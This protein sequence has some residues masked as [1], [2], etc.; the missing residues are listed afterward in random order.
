VRRLVDRPLLLLKLGRL[1]R[2]FH[3][4]LFHFLLPY[5]VVPSF[6]L[7][8]VDESLLFTLLRRIRLESVL[9]QPRTGLPLLLAQG[10]MELILGLG[11]LLSLF[12]R[13]HKIRFVSLRGRG[14]LIRRPLLRWVLVGKSLHEIV[15]LRRR[16]A[17]WRFSFFDDQLVENF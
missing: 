2:Y 8:H 16:G 12:E 5:R 13:F 17:L 11:H 4:G 6:P 1:L 10:L 9:P 3:L 14:Y 15:L 7:Q